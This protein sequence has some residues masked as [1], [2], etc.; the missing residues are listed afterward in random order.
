MR[1]TIIREELRQSSHRTIS[2]ID[3]RTIRVSVSEAPHTVGEVDGPRLEHDRSQPQHT[4]EVDV[5][6]GGTARRITAPTAK[7]CG[8]T[9][10]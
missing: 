6:A 10:A 3:L 1:V 4:Q 7:V 5:S 8:A 2:L 9:K